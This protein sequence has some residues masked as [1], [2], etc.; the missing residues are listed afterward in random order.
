MP[1]FEQI[2]LSW[3]GKDYFIEPDNVMRAIAKVE[4]VITLVQIARC[5]ET[6]DIPLVKIAQAYAAV[7]RHAGARVEDDEVYNDLFQNGELQKRAW[8]AINT[9]QR[10]MIPPDHLRQETLPGKGAAG[11]TAPSSKKRSKQQ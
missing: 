9:L 5:Y 2:T 8:A 11:E 6:R 1:I 10:M 7:L 4:D 3:G